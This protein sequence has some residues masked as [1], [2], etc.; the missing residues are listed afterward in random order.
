MINRADHMI[1]SL[2]LTLA[3]TARPGT[4]RSLVISPFW[5]LCHAAMGVAGHL[6]PQVYLKI[7]LISF[8]I[9]R[10]PDFKPAMTMSP[11]IRLRDDY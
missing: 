10:I 5:R 1:M 6:I 11:E 9:R 3:R 2:K 7:S 4:G 8:E